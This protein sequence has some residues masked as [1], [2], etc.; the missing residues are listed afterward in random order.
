MASN[1][2]NLDLYKKDPLTDGQD[3]FNIETMLNDNWD[4]IDAAF[5]DVET[6]QG[7]QEKV[8]DLA[9]AGRTTETVKGIADALTSHLNDLTQRA[10]N[11]MYPPSPLTPAAFDGETDDS[12]AIQDIVDYVSQN[13]GGIVFLPA[14]T[15]VFKYPVFVSS[16]VTIIGQGLQ[17]R[18]LA[19]ISLGEG[20]CAFLVGDSYEW[21][22][23]TTS[24][25]RAAETFG[26]LTNGAFT[27]I[28]LGEGLDLTYE[29]ERIVTRDAY[30]MNLFIEFDYS[31]T[32]STWGGYGIQFA[33]AARCGAKNIWT[34][35][36]TQAIGVG[37]DVI[38]SHPACVEIELEN[39]VVIQP[40]PVRTYYAIVFFA[41]SNNC[42]IRNAESRVP[43]T[44]DSPDGSVIATN[45]VK[46]IDIKDIRMNVGKSSTSEG[47]L[48]NNSQGCNVDGIY[49]EN[50]RKGIATLYHETSY[51]SSS[52][53]N[54]ITNVYLK[55]SERAI[56]IASK[57][58]IFE[59]FITLNC[60]TDISFMNVNGTNNTIINVPVDN[61]TPPPGQSINWILDH[62]N[63]IV[64][65]RSNVRY[66]SIY[67]EFSRFISI[68]D[69][70]KVNSISLSF[71]RFNAS[72][73][74]KIVVPLNLLGIQSFSS[75]RYFIFF[76]AGS[77]TADSSVTTRLLRRANFTGNTSVPLTELASITTTPTSDNAQDRE[78]N[79]SAS[80]A[81]V[82]DMGQ[83][84]ILE[85]TWEN[86]VNNSNIKNG[87]IIVPS[88]NAL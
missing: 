39:I 38:P 2:P 22:K 8:D 51:I 16:N 1:T 26:P 17:T 67:F 55:D 30:I 20:R 21:N 45:T 29:D 64:K 54:R 68:L 70:D 43:M 47:I 84:L 72:P 32:M 3:T 73:S 12:G 78:I 31:E 61:V 33:Q 28:P 83:E 24:S 80:V 19:K 36:A 79:L 41:N 52:N 48:L 4:K 59:N 25:R 9:G 65:P 35:N 46:G 40:D 18:V 53:P 50:A 75:L 86:V 11:V 14:G 23:E 63:N 88:W 81:P 58:D 6:K 27:D 60:D 57:F 62:N 69:A 44:V 66:R 77:Q 85:I 56:N 49:V 13:G 37:S 42:S 87:R 76:N 71:V 5:E 7:A 34:K 82:S 10:V 15:T 74:I